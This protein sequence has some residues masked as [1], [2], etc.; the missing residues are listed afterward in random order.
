MRV[1]AALLM[2]AASYLHYLEKI[3]LVPPM[4]A[5]EVNL[6]R[7]DTTRIRL[8]KGKDVKENSHRV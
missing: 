8:K 3:L 7:S 5:E 2:A 6:N 1:E 4:V